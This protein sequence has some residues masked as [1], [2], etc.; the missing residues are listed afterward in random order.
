MRIRLDQ[1]DNKLEIGLPTYRSDHEDRFY[2]K[3]VHGTLGSPAVEKRSSIN[4]QEHKLRQNI[5]S[6]Q[7]RDSVNFELDLSDVI[8]IF[9][10]LRQT[11]EPP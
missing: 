5:V 9:E 1:N 10:P 4:V 11:V 2:R 8:P 3:R 7:E 6:F